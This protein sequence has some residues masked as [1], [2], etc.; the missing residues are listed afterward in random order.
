MRAADEAKAEEDGGEK[1]NKNKY[2]DD[3]VLAKTLMQFFLDGY[4]T[5]GSL[6]GVSLYYLAMH[7]DVQAHDTFFCK[8]SRN[9]RYTFD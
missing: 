4:D 9:C 7:Q 5:I 3:S 8:F 2:L 1:K 6:I